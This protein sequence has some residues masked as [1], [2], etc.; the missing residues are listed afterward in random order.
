MVKKCPKLPISRII[1]TN[2]LQILQVLK[3]WINTMSNNYKTH[4]HTLQKNIFFFD[5]H[6]YPWKQRGARHQVGEKRKF[7]ARQKFLADRVAG[8][9]QIW[10]N[11]TF[12]PNWPPSVAVFNLNKKQKSYG[13]LKLVIQNFGC[14]PLK[15]NNQLET[16]LPG[17][18]ESIEKTT[19]PWGYSVPSR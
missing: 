9:P 18:Y 6:H 17:M 7:L 4:G 8:D 13:A 11:D 10:P 3:K 2:F 5:W 16:P 19:C 14:P 15:W 1:V 12:W